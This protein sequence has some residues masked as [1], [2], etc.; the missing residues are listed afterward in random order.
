MQSQRSTL[1]RQLMQRE[2][3]GEEEE[4]ANSLSLF[5]ILVEQ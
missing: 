5:F 1:Y 3:E 2:K 4:G